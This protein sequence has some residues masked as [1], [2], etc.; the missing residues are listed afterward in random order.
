MTA[1]QEFQAGSVGDCYTDTFAVSGQPGSPVICGV[2][3]GQHLIVDACD[4]CHTVNF[5]IAT[6]SVTRAWTIHITQYTCQEDQNS[7][8]GP[9]GCLQWFTGTTGRVSSFG[10]DRTITAVSA[11]A[12]THLSSQNYQVC[13]RRQSSYCYICYTPVIEGTVL[14]ETKQGSFGLSVS[15]GTAA[16]AAGSTVDQYCNNDRL[17]IAGKETAA[18]AAI[19]DISAT[20]ATGAF[21]CGRYMNTSA[22]QAASA[23]TCTRNKPFVLGVITDE[24]ENY[25]VDTIWIAAKAEN[26]EAALGPGGIIGFDLYWI[27]SSC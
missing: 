20:Q 15:A 17:T 4:D 27:Q 12:A 1:N 8:G 26:V 9:P 21:V 24:D 5:N 3:T 10:Y 23:T 18:N 19:L 7:Q 11:S 16:T 25:A 22:A 14:V 6:T 13:F 2:N